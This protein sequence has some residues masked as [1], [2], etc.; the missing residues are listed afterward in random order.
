MSHF[1]NGARKQ[2]EQRNSEEGSYPAELGA[3]KCTAL[4]QASGNN[5]H[6]GTDCSLRESC[7]PEAALECNLLYVH[8]EVVKRKVIRIYAQ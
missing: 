1:D 6:F 5:V 8:Q 2:S 7:V 3:I 4:M